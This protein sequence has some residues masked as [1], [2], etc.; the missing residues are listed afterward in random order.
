MLYIFSTLVPFYFMLQVVNKHVTQPVLGANFVICRVHVLVFE[1][2]K[3]NF[4]LRSI[5]IVCI[6]IM[7]VS[8]FK[9]NILYIFYKTRMIFFNSTME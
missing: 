9:N 6:L 2:G 7:L 3:L 1:T 5:Y 8:V 4:L